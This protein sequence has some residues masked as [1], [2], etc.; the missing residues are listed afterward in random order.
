MGRKAEKA[1]AKEEAPMRQTEQQLLAEANAVPTDLTPEEKANIRRARIGNL[2]EGYGLIGDRMQRHFGRIG[3]TVGQPE[4]ELELGRQREREKSKAT[5]ETEA[6]LIE[7]PVRRRMIRAGMLQPVYST[8]SGR[9]TGFQQQ[10]NQGFD[11][12]RLI[13]AGA[14]AASLIPTGGGSAAAGGCWVAAAIYGEDAFETRLLRAWL[15]THLKDR[16]WGR[17]FV[18]VY[19]KYGERVAVWISGRAWAKAIL[20]RVIFDRLYRMA[21]R[22]M[23]TDEVLFGGGYGSVL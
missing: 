15:N 10:A 12:A 20:K 5:A 8:Q 9:Y 2:D 3:S 23:S 18:A 19:L 11:W 13:G 17:C 14:M 21:C 6:D 22:E 4:A 16:L 7:L 1:A